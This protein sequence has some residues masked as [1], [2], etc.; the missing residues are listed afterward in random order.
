M[1]LGP[2]QV[3][4]QT[5]SYA[6]SEQA[7]IVDKI[8]WNNHTKLVI[9]NDLR[10]TSKGSAILICSSYFSI[11]QGAEFN[12]RRRVRLRQRHKTRIS[13]VKRGKIIVLHVRRTFSGILHNNVKLTN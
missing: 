3:L 7:T 12:K 11:Q 1:A 8:P 6:G 13:L 10:I 4:K 2:R 9:I 5:F